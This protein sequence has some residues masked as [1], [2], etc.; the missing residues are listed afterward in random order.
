MPPKP[1][2]K[3]SKGV[4]VSQT[5]ISSYPEASTE[6]Y[7]PTDD[8]DLQILMDAAITEDDWRDVFIKA[9]EIALSGGMVGVKAMEFLAKYRWGMPATMTLASENAQAQITIVEVV[10]SLPTQPPEQLTVSKPAVDPLDDKYDKEA[11]AEKD[12]PVPF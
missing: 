5:N 3:V 7:R 9:K 10:R 8:R 11:D 1:T 2:R 12:D 6:V 4:L